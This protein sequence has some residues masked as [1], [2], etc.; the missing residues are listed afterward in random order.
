MKNLKSIST[1]L[2]NGTIIMSCLEG[3]KVDTTTI[4][5]SYTVHLSNIL[6]YSDLEDFSKLHNSIVEE[7]IVM[8]TPRE[9]TVVYVCSA[10]KNLV[11]S[12]KHGTMKE[13]KK[14]MHNNIENNI[15]GDY[16]IFK[17]HI[18]SISNS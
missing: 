5:D 8:T 17:G 11:I 2:E 13:I 10:T 3:N 18:N 4:Y 14:E 15:H 12:Q 16:R 6:D 1:K 9:Y 7:E